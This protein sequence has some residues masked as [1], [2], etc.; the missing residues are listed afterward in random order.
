MKKLYTLFCLTILTIKIQAQTLS[1]L[2]IEFQNANSIAYKMPLAGGLNCPQFSPVDMN[3]DGKQDIFVFDRIGNV[4]LTYLNNGSDF[5]YTPQYIA[6]FPEL[7]DWALL[8]DYNGDGIADIFTFNN[9]AFSGVRIFKGKMVN[10]QITFDRVN[11]T[12]NGN[13]LNYPLSN[14]TRTKTNMS[15]LPSL[16]IS[17]GLN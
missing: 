9:G 10:N 13:I 3:N 4:R 17:T 8:R 12:S 5:D 11:F 6:Q 15:C 1:R 2:N 14:G 16:F 7:N